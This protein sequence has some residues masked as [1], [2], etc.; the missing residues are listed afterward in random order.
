METPIVDNN[1]SADS[2][3]KIDKSKVLEYGKGGVLD[4]TS[5]T[6]QPFITSDAKTAA[7]EVELIGGY[8]YNDPISGDVKLLNQ[9]I[10]REMTGHEEDIMTNSRMDIGRRFHSMISSCMTR[11]GDGKGTYITDESKMHGIVDE[12]TI[13]DRWQLLLFLRIISVPNGNEFIF[14]ASCPGCGYSFPKTADLYQLRKYAMV[15]PMERIYDVVVPSGK[16]CRCQVML[17]KHEK[18]VSAAQESG[19]NV[20][21]LDLMARVL[22]IDGKPSTMATIKDLLMRD[23]NFLRNE[24][25]RREGGIDTAIQ[26]S[27]SACNRKFEADID[28]GQKSFF[29]PSSTLKV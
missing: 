27:C 5:V 29:F 25:K 6:P 14:N 7:G 12:L 20:L 1:Q 15:N 24:F 11:I 10:M 26:M 19:Q 13:S 16:S 18:T 28:M 22:E 23:R 8:I 4:T 9:V 21:S 2:E 17:G 3:F